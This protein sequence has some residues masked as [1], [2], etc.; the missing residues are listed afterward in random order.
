MKGILQEGTGTVDHA[1]RILLVEDHADTAMAMQM[2]LERKGYEVLTATTCES[3]LEIISGHRFD[4]LISDIRLPDGS[5]LDLMRRLQLGRRLPGIALSDDNSDDEIRRS[6]EAGF[7]RHLHKPV[8][9]FEL[10]S[11]IRTMSL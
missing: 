2:L 10:F 6:K 5:G 4:L 1:T 11:T 9:V 7:F 3:A 8:N